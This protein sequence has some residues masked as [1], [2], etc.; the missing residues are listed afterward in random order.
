[1]HMTVLQAGMRG[2]FHLSL[3][4]VDLIG[5]FVV[6]ARF[7]FVF[8]LQWPGQIHFQGRNALTRVR[9]SEREVQQRETW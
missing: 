2:C 3:S 6:R 7:A 9:L 5:C 4:R 8:C 1:M